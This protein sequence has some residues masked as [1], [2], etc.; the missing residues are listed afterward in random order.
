MVGADLLRYDKNQLYL[1]KDYETEGVNLYYS[2]P[3]QVSYI[4]FNL[5]EILD[6][7]NYYIWFDDFKV[8]KEAARIT[9]FNYEYYKQMALPAN[10][11]LTNIDK[12]IYDPNI[13]TVTHNFF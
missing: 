3:W 8:S 12:Y 9:R 7:Q 11:V 5:N 13:I 1:A 6:R 2:R 10:Q 4:L